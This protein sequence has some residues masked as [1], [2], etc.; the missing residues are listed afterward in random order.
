MARRSGA[1]HLFQRRAP[2]SV[3]GR[4][5]SE[6]TAVRCITHF[7]FTENRTIS[8]PNLHPSAVCQILS[9]LPNF[10]SLASS[11]TQ[12]SRRLRGLQTRNH[13]DL[14][15]SRRPPSDA[16]RTFTQSC[17]LLKEVVLSDGIFSSALFSDPCMVAHGVWPSLES[18]TLTMCGNLLVPSGAWYFTGEE[19]QPEPPVPSHRKGYKFANADAPYWARI[20]QCYFSDT[21]HCLDGRESDL[22][23]N[24]GD[25]VEELDRFTARVG[26]K[27]REGDWHWGNY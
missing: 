22:G 25:L 27:E 7:N 4:V 3:Y 1:A 24:S 26:R 18:L 10:Q 2:S 16:L 14:A 11:L 8:Y 13:R 15:E 23:W 5:R 17:P 12:P 6:S 19:V 21:T 20:A 9:S